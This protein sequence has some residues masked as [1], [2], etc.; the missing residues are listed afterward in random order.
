MDLKECFGQDLRPASV[1]SKRVSRYHSMAAT[2]LLR[3]IPDFFFIRTWVS[4]TL[5]DIPSHRGDTD[6]ALRAAIMPTTFHRTVSS[7]N[8]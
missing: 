1:T 3:D 5:S 2:I 8:S 4:C 7:P 6:T